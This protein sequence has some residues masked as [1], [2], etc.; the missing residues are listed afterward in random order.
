[1]ALSFPSKYRQSLDLSR[2]AA[3][4]TLIRARARND[5]ESADTPW[6]QETD[7]ALAGRQ[8][9]HRVRTA[10]SHAAVDQLAASASAPLRLDGFCRTQGEQRI[11]HN[12]ERRLIRLV[13]MFDERESAR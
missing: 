12:F 8:T 5:E 9:F 10:P 13:A 1:M 6:R 2:A 11:A 3:R 4:V 7:A